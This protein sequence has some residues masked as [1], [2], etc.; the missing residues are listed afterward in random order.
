MIALNYLTVFTATYN[1]ADLLK[2]LYESLKQQTE[3]RFEWL[4]ID[5]ESTDNTVSN[6]QQWVGENNGFE[7]NVV[8]QT[9]GGKHRALNVGFD[10]AKGDYFFI[11]DSDD[12][13]TTD[14]IENIYKWILQIDPLD[15]YAGISGL[16]ISEKGIVWGGSGH[17]NYEYI[18]ATGFERRKLD[19]CGDK[20]EIY[21]TSILRE[22]KFPE[23]EGEDFVTEEVCWLNIAHKGY[24]LRWHNTPIYICEYLE[25]GLTK[26]GA[27]EIEGHKKNM[28]GYLFYIRECLLKKPFIEKMLNFREYKKTCD[29]LKFS[30]SERCDKVDM[31]RVKYY[32]YLLIGVPIG[33]IL[34]KMLGR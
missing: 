20:A 24:K 11:V 14:A 7:I 10:I 29:I 22:N 5:D 13:L 19:L 18:D 1:R 12:Q 16:K 23:F 4:I 3:K 9:H 28:K 30:V 15:K 34:R 27:N 25:D 32:Y 26:N 8:K 17:N 6:I 33:Y 31:S 21:K 2:R